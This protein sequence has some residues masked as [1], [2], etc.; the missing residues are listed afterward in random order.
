MSHDPFE[1]RWIMRYN[2][3]DTMHQPSFS[4]NLNVNIV[5]ISGREWTLMVPRWRRMIC[6][7]RLRPIP[8]PSCFVVKK[9]INIF[10]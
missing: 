8:E 9:G 6:R 2:I 7:E 3:I 4:Q 1:I 10:P 5:S